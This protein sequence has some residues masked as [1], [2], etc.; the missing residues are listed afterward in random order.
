MDNKIALASDHAGFERKQAIIRYFINKAISFEDLGCYT[1]ESCDYSDFG[2][3]IARAISEGFY[4]VGITFCGTG[5]GISITTNKYPKIRSALCWNVEIAR[6]A[7]QHN[8]ANICSIPGRFVT[9]EEA[10]EIVETFLGTA[11]EGGRH[12]RRIDKISADFKCD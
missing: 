3:K 8:D 10:V 5:Q 7:R 12:Q 1:D 6:L 9:D 4:S 2:H 11:F